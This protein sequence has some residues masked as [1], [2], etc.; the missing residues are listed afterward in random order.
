MKFESMKMGGLRAAQNYCERHDG[1]KLF[2]VGALF[3]PDRKF[4]PHYAFE[5]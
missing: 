2:R 3:L 1:R 5:G 4:L